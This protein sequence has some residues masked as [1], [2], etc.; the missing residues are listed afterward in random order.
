M[1]HLREPEWIKVW[2]ELEPANVPLSTMETIVNAVRAGLSFD[3]VHDLSGLSLKDFL[4]SV[5]A[6]GSRC[7]Q[8]GR[9]TFSIVSIAQADAAVGMRVEHGNDGDV[10]HAAAGWLRTR[11][12]GD[13]RKSYAAILCAPPQVLSRSL[14]RAANA[15]ADTVELSYSH[16]ADLYGASQNTLP[17]LHKVVLNPHAVSPY[18]AAWDALDARTTAAVSAGERLLRGC[19]L[20][21]L[22]ENLR[23]AFWLVPNARMLLLSIRATQVATTPSARLA[24]SEKVRSHMRMLREMDNRYPTRLRPNDLAQLNQQQFRTIV[25]MDGFHPLGSSTRGDVA[26]DRLADE[27]RQVLAAE[28]RRVLAPV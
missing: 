13:V 12:S 19:D 22:K 7:T 9:G 15:A 11:R 6:V 23:E 21:G 20:E 2:R 17:A 26:T 5:A 14:E 28:S 25:A 24:G 10:V 4:S 1:T 16:Y 3:D 8:V 27:A 18:L